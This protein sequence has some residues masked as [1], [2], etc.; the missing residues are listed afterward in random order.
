MD[1]LSA[2]ATIFRNEVDI[3]PFQIVLDKWKAVIA[4]RRNLDMA[5]DYHISLTD[6]PLPVP[7]KVLIL[8]EQWM[9]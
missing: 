8:K 1:S 9:M 2:E 6:S 5:L 3:Y 7:V 4:G